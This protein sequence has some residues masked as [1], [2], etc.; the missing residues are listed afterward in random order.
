MIYRL[1]QLLFKA[2]ISVAKIEWTFN[3]ME[4]VKGFLWSTMSDEHLDSQG[5]RRGGAGGSKRP[6]PFLKGARG[7]EMPFLNCFYS[8][9]SSVFQPENTTEGTLC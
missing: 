9:I 7:S 1:S 8:D 2:P 5:R 3:R 6:L 4:T